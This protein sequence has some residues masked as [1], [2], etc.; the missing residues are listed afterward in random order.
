MEVV[1]SFDFIISNKLKT[2]FD[3]D[4]ESLCTLFLDKK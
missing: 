4:F 3:V 1:K 2:K